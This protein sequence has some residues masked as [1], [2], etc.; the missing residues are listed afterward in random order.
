[1]KDQI[2]L[3][4]PITAEDIKNRIHRVCVEVT[5]EM[6]VHVRECFRQR[7]LKCILVGH[8]FEHRK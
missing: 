8:H 6:L 7:I 5:P 2:M 4:A 3:T 1:M